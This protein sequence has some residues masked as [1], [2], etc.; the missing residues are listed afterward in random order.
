MK[1]WNYNN[2]VNKFK[3]SKLNKCMYTRNIVQAKP[4]GLTDFT[5]ES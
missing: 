1:M 5:C 3:K 2:Q 4:V